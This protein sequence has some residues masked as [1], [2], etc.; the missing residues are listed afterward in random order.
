MKKQEINT[1]EDVFQDYGKSTSDTENS[2]NEELAFW[3]FIIICVVFL[4]IAAIWVILQIIQPE[5]LTY[6]P[7]AKHN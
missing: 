1:E 5:E 4:T 7:R 6:I 3:L 2:R